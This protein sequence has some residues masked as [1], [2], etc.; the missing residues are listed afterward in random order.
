MGHLVSNF[1]RYAIDNVSCISPY[2]PSACYW[3]MLWFSII[4]QIIWKWTQIASN[5]CVF[6]HNYFD[7][8]LDKLKNYKINIDK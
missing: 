8:T 3:T 5:F 1:V 2:T 7:H 4:S 6:I